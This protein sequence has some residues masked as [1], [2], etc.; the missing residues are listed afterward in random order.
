MINI[1][2]GKIDLLNNIRV[3]T[4][5]PKYKKEK[6]KR[7]DSDGIATKRSYS[8]INTSD[9]DEADSEPSDE[10]TFTLRSSNFTIS[11]NPTNPTTNIILAQPPKKPSIWSHLAKK[12]ER[13]PKL[14]PV[15]KPID[16]SEAFAMILTDPTEI[17][18]IKAKMEA[19]KVLV[20]K[21]KAKGQIALSESL[22]DKMLLTFFEDRLVMNDFKKIVPENLMIEFITNY[23][24]ALELTYIRNYMREIP[25]SVTDLKVKADGL[26]VFDNYVVLHT[27]PKAVKLTKEEEKVEEARK[28]DPILFGLI[29]DSRKFYYIGAWVDE[30]CDLTFDAFIEKYGDKQLEMMEQIPIAQPVGTTINGVTKEEFTGD[31]N[32]PGCARCH[33]ENI[34]QG[35]T[36]K[37]TT[38][39]IQKAFLMA[40]LN[41]DMSPEASDKFIPEIIKE[42]A[43]ESKQEESKEPTHD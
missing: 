36:L 7:K 21:T 35:K 42:L 33:P 30:L 15:E 11:T 22:S 39:N 41:S 23:A 17:S 1:T 2:N 28:R 40:K 10:Q 12:F 5:L 6:D 24:K 31:C 19:Y 3:D 13:S 26:H 4:S 37:E 27:D 14:P 32:N 34:E 16:P 38:A 18:I 20:T 9:D 8:S 43:P 29:K 25:D